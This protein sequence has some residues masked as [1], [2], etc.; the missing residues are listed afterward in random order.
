MKASELVKMVEKEGWVFDRQKGSHMTFEKQGEPR[1]LIIPNH[2][3]KDL[4][5]FLVLKILK[6][7][8]LR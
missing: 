1:P 4:N 5:K 2:G 3:S 7:A 6:Q 8:G